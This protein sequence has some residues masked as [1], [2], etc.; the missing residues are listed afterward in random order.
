MDNN[1]P[2]VVLRKILESIEM[3]T[4]DNEQV[5]LLKKVVH[6]FNSLVPLYELLDQTEFQKWDDVFHLY[7]PDEE[8]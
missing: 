3:D 1:D 5:E 2:K 4:L 6:W 7:F 8:E